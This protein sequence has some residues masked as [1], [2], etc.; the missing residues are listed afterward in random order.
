MTRQELHDFA[1]FIKEYNDI[2]I[3]DEIVE[4]RHGVKNIGELNFRQAVD[5]YD[6]VHKLVDEP[7]IKKKNK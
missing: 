1:I 4:L 7:K 2:S 5:A 6:K 3:D